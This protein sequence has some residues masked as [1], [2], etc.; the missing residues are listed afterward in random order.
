M[1]KGFWMGSALVSVALALSMSTAALAQADDDTATPDDA[2]IVDTTGSTDSSP[3]VDVSMDAPA[4]DASV[5]PA[6]FLQLVDPADED[7]EVPLETTELTLRGITVPGAV[8]SVDGDLVDTDDQGNF[9]A[10]TALDE[11]ANDIDVVV[12]DAQGNQQTTTLFV[13]RGQ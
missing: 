3:A 12:S 10:V 9:T 2:A 13:V 6:L 1:L 8:V 5:A 4:N 7:V 11:G